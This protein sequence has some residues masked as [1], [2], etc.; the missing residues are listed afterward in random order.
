MDCWVLGCGPSLTQVQ[1]P[2]DVF[3]IGIN[4]SYKHHW[5]PVWC[6]TDLR[7]LR[8]DYK[9]DVPYRPLV[10]LTAIDPVRVGVHE[11]PGKPLIQI[12]LAERVTL[13]KGGVFGYWAAL[14]LFGATR[15]HLL[16]FDMESDCR[17]FDAPEHVLDQT[18]VSQRYQLV[19]LQK[20]FGVESWIW[21]RGGFFPVESLP[22]TGMEVRGINYIG[23]GEQD[24]TKGMPM[25]QDYWKN[26]PQEWFEKRKRM[27]IEAKEARERGDNA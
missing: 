26:L 12:P 24:V 1:I 13:R 4:N 8:R 2:Q 20:Q 27:A 3:T 6:G 11:V 18:Y 22:T 21:H 19:Q 15:V 5:S 9:V 23:P 16:G 14:K 10:Y 17:H 7:A 25:P